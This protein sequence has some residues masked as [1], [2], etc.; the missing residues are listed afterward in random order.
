M[1]DRS[2]WHY[3]RDGKSRRI[4]AI[5]PVLQR[6]VNGFSEGVDKSGTESICLAEEGF[7]LSKKIE[8]RVMLLKGYGNAIVP[9][10]AAEFIGAVM[11]ILE[12]K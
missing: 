2:Q 4:P 8:G 9:P 3:C 7:P 6:V 5:E 1:W 10:V 12:G 11:E